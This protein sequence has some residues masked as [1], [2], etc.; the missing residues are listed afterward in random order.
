MRG[1]C[2]R[3]VSKDREVIDD[4]RGR[5]AYRL[6]PHALHPAHDLYFGC[7]LQEECVQR[8]STPETMKVTTCGHSP[9]E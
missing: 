3:T 1:L 8:G 7:L 9:V 5:S 6:V 2:P 4:E